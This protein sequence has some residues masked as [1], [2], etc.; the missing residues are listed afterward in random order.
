MIIKHPFRVLLFSAVIS[1]ISLG[2]ALAQQAARINYQ[3]VARRADGTPVAS[4]NI[5]LRLTIK[6]GSATGATV[7]SEIRQTTTNN[8]GLFNVVIGSS[9][10]VSNSGTVASVNWA[11]GN[12]YLQVEIDPQGGNNFLALGTSQLQSV[13]YAIYANSASPIGTAAGDLSGTYPNPKVSKIQGNAI[14]IATPLS[15]QILQ[16]NGTAWEP[17]SIVGEAGP[18]GLPGQDGTTLPEATASS[19]GKIQLSGD[20]AGT[21]STAAEPRI[22]SNAITTT[23]IADLNV[24]DAKIAGLSG[25]KLS[26]D[27]AGNAA[28]VTG[29]VALTNGGTGAIT[30]AEAITNLGAEALSNKSTAVDLGST[31]ASDNKYPS[32]KAVKTYVDAQTASARVSDGSITNEKLA[33]SIAASKLI[34]TDITKVGTITAGIWNGTTVAVANGGS[35]AT[36]LSGYVKGNGTNSLTA[37]ATIPAADITG[38]IKKVN[39][40]LPDANGFITI[41]LGSVSTGALANLPTNAGTNGNIYVVSGDATSAE[42]G[43]TFISDG[44]TWKEVTSNQAATDARYL[45]LAGGTLAGSLTIPTA[46]VLT[47]TDAPSNYTDATNKSYVD[48]AIANSTI[49]DATTSSAGKIQLAGDL[50]GVGSSASAPKV[51]TVGG[52]TAALINSAEVLANAAVSTNTANQLV[53]RDASGNFDANIITAN[54]TGNVTGNIIGNVSGTASNV[55]G[56][57]GVANG[58]SG[59]TSLTGYLI[60]NGTSAFTSSA[61]IPASAVTGLIKKVNGSAPDADGNVSIAFGTVSTGTLSG[62]PVSAGTNGNIYVVSGDAT[63][64][65]NG[66]TYISDGSTWKEV[67][68]N[69]AATDARYLKLAGGTLAGNIII[70]TTNKITLTDAPTVS[71]DAVNKAYVDASTAGASIADATTSTLGKIQLAGDLAGAGTSATSPKISSVGGSTAVLINS[72]EVLANAAVSINT[73]NQLVKRDALGNFSAG[74]ITSNLTGNVTGNATNVMGVVAGVNGGTGV[75]NNGKTITIGGNF[76]TLHSLKFTTA[77]V[78]NL[79]LPTSGTLATVQQLEAKELLSNKSTAVDL[80]ST[81]PSDDKYPSQKAVKTY[82]DGKAS[83]FVSPAFTGIPTAPTATS[84]NSTTQIATTAFVMSAVVDPRSNFYIGVNENLGLGSFTALPA[85]SGKY[86]TLIGNFTIQNKNAGDGTTAL[87]YSA[88][89]YYGSSGTTTV[90]TVVGGLYLGANTRASANNTSNEIV[91]GYDALGRGSNTIQLGNTSI[92]NVYTSGNVFAKGVQL[93]SDY[94]LKKNIIPIKDGISTIMK[95]NPVNYDKKNSLDAL[96]YDKKENGFIAQ[97]IQ[98]VIPYIVI[99]GEDNDKLLSVDYTS[100]IPVLTKAIQEQQ[101]IIEQLKKSNELYAEQIK[102]LTGMIEK[103]LEDKSHK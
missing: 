66:R 29:T 32:Q 41:P 16:W 14:S 89:N 58:G 33:G 27:I 84:G 70:P 38:L 25:S 93:S 80:G 34:G 52:S 11:S 77:G 60:G 86:N 18:R 48:V 39:G 26:G 100:I 78:T 20:L 95:L 76:E 45:Q 10:T 42:N 30:A 54:L 2:Q 102:K 1:L 53:K 3:A 79:T 43:R 101:I 90:G 5:S 73:A 4:Q 31:L 97:E 82:V 68:S 71:T 49:A 75:A 46:K 61:S 96:N 81:T 6:D 37:S 47:I 17:S 28:N 55:T 7:Y 92:L 98:K 65:E 62:R 8:F 13:P 40:S 9:G 94:R 23:K 44:S 103:I 50:A 74:T 24:T 99:E 59:A 83:S 35:G 51:S 69:Q 12:K 88:G 22:S 21:N 64:A 67:T 56:T 91:L 85:Q 87:G 72:A 36:S 63:T 19:L 15:G 57:V